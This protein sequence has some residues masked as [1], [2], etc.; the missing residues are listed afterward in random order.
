MMQIDGWRNGERLQPLQRVTVSGAAGG[1]VSVRDG[2]GR[3]YF[4][5]PDSDPLEFTVGGALGYHTVALED[6]RGRVCE[7]LTFRVDAETQLHDEGGR[8]GEL[9]QMLLYTMISEFGEA[10]SVR[11]RGRIYHFFICWLRDHVHVLKGMKYFYPTLK[12][13]IDLY[14]ESQR[15]DGMIWDNVYPRTPEANYWDTRFAEGGFIRPFDDYTAEFKRIP[16]ENDVEYLFVEGLYYTWKATGDDGWMADSLDAAVRAYEYSVT[17]PYRWSEKYRLLKRG[18]TIDTWDFQDEPDCT[19]AGDAMG[20][21]PGQTHFGVM[22]GDNTGYAAGCRQLAEMLAHVGRDEEAGRY[23]ER[24]REI[25]QRLDALA[26]NG[27]FYTHHVREDD[28]WRPDLGVDERTQLSLSNAYSLNRGLTHDQCVAIIRTYQRL[29]ETLPEGSP[30]EWYTIYPPF[31]KGYGGH[32][33]LW[34]YMNGGVTP[35]VAGELAH[36]AFEHG[37][38]AYAVDI[39]H[40]LFDL[41]QAHGGKFHSA[42]TGAFP[43]TAPRQWTPLD[44]AAQANISLDGEGAPGVPGW[45]GE[46]DNDLHEMPTGD[47][48]LVGVPFHLP[49]PET[50]GRRSAIGL[51]WTEDYAQWVEIP[52]GATA[53]SVYFLHTSANTSSGVAGSVT[54]HYT[55]GTDHTRYVIR[56]QNVAGWWL[57]EAPGGHSTLVCEVAWRGK[58]AHCGNVGVLAWGLDNPHPDK[59]IARL[60]LRASEDGAFWAVLGVTL[61]DQPAA[62]PPGP[63]S[64][65]IPNGWSAAAVVYALVE[66]LAGVVD[67]GVCYNQVTLSPRW[68][69]AGVSAATVTVR[70]PASDGYVAYAY[71]H[72]PERRALGLVLTGS[73][74]ACQCHLLLPSEATG[75]RGVQADGQDVDFAVRT[76]EQSRYVDFMLDTLAP[77]TV[78]VFY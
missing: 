71:R 68:L 17:D 54:L 50:N 31:P 48:E 11:W 5:G 34:Q 66:G 2:R 33:G 77:Q 36:G 53:A 25:K 40:R 55:D 78:T 44:I 45:T 1:A 52:V 10:H 13:A 16:V 76:V 61:C 75:V 21:E 39:L 28:D 64:F 29:Q 57:P 41:A 49:D 14:R 60:T 73:G 35:I 8:F 70:Y 6:D 4:R 15:E 59:T 7:T 67:A 74:E 46:G 9:L 18:H 37:F 32:N 27:R 30:G 38:E 69:A 19:V 58:N 65:G 72:D 20:V 62:F 47:L 12:D 24:G 63:I 23:Q 3:E 42:Y 26:W 22:F 56:G 43:S 51:R